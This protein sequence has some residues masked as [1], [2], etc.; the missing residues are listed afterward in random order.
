M[1]NNK[2]IYSILITIALATIFCPACESDLIGILLKSHD[3]R[4]NVISGS[5]STKSV[6]NA[7]FVKEIEFEGNCLEGI[8]I[9]EY[10]SDN[11]DAF[12]EIL[13]RGQIATGSNFN[14]SGREFSIEAYLAESIEDADRSSSADKAD[15]H[16]IAGRTVSYSGTE[17]KWTGGD[18]PE[19][20]N[21]IATTLWAYYPVSVSGRTLHLPDGSTPDDAAQKILSFDYT[22]PEPVTT[23]VKTDAENQQDLLFSYNLET[24]G[25]NDAGN[26]SRRSSSNAEYSRTDNQV[27][28]RFF[29]ALAAVKFDITGVAGEVTVDNI[30]LVN[31]A[32]GGSCTI[33]AP[34]VSEPTNSF[35]WTP[36]TTLKTYS[37]D[38]SSSN[39]FETVSG[40]KTQKMS[41]D[42]VFFM[43]PQ[44]LGS[45]AKLAVT[46]TINGVTTT[47][48]STGVSGD[49]W[50]AG[51]YY[52]YA[53]KKT[54]GSL[55]VDILGEGGILMTSAVDA[56]YENAIVRFNKTKPSS[57]TI[58]VTK[59]DGTVS[60]SFADA[61]WLR[62]AA[63][64]SAT[65][66]AA[67]PGASS[68]I[69]LADLMTELT[70]S[71]TK[72]HFLEDGDYLYTQAFIDECYYAGQN[73]TSFVNRSK[74]S[75]T[76]TITN[77]KGSD[78]ATIEQKAMQS[79][80]NLSAA[81]PFGVE[82][83]EENT[84]TAGTDAATWCLSRNR[85][86]DGNGVIEGSEIKWRVPSLQEYWNIWYGTYSMSAESW[87]G[88]STSP[89]RELYLSSDDGFAYN[90]RLG[91]TVTGVS[92]TGTVRCI[93]DLGT[94]SNSMFALA[95]VP[96]VI[97]NGDAEKKY[98]ITMN[99]VSDASLRSRISGR[100][101][102]SGA[103]APGEGTDCADNKL[104]SSIQ[105]ASQY[106]TWPTGTTVNVPVLLYYLAVEKD[107]AKSYDD[108]YFNVQCNPKGNITLIEGRVK[109]I[110]PDPRL[111]Y[112]STFIGGHGAVEPSYEWS[113]LDNNGVLHFHAEYT[114]WNA[115]NSEVSWII[116]ASIN[117]GD[118][119]TSDLSGGNT[120]SLI[121]Y[122][123]KATDLSGAWGSSYKSTDVILIGVDYTAL[124]TSGRYCRL[125]IQDGGPYTLYDVDFPGKSEE[126]DGATAGVDD[127]QYS[128]FLCRNY[129]YEDK[130][131]RN[132]SPVKGDLGTWRAPNQRELSIMLANRS[133]LKITRAVESGTGEYIWSDE[134]WLITDKV[135]TPSITSSISHVT[136]YNSNGTLSTGGTAPYRI[137]CVR[138]IVE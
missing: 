79:P 138:D 53:L 12:C 69:G 59:P 105:V 37:Q 47:M 82:V 103:I 88:L 55:S 119:T 90:G 8:T 77:A 22:L 26:I 125:G 123:G 71:G 72:T 64:A 136:Y 34:I 137:R 42:K 43:I 46:F 21:N 92:G 97:D 118:G 11:T 120:C 102:T 18:A 10:V 2:N 109:M 134:E 104:Y 30:S 107:R 133:G 58:S 51:K 73:L 94:G 45:N 127:K 36:G 122:V 85:D 112:E 111:V 113:Y 87:L 86:E 57:Y 31:V 99:G 1:K 9:S 7:R 19:W 126:F 20:R 28:I 74:R 56:H 24:C 132:G 29:H 13:T 60:S 4:I 84:A 80:Y 52:T 48:Y 32:S 49:K 15:Y 39:D 44:T 62:F 17:W 66:F 124:G 135:S 115:N 14:T 54:S 114:G 129:Y 100:E 63:P 91:T 98:V 67:Y 27:D 78:S 101:L 75:A 41:G 89:A 116:N 16:F 23:A 40:R 70:G 50:E 68:T 5:H 121:F 108:Y 38:F 130:R 81:N 33:S 61:S 3:I 106:L 131:T 25:F 128:E 93:R 117:N 83:I 110:N 95:E 65:A 96:G 6:D 76:I 35:A